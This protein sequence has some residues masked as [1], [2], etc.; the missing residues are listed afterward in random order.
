MLLGSSQGVSGELWA[1]RCL[2]ILLLEH[3]LLELR[4]ELWVEFECILTQLGLRAEA[5]GTVSESVLAEGYS[6][7]DLCGFSVELVRRLSRLNRVHDAIRGSRCEPA[8]WRYFLRTARD[9]SKLT[10]ARYAIPA[11][12]VL[13]EIESRLLITRGVEDPVERI[14]H[15]EGQGRAPK[16]LNAPA[17]ETSIL[18]GLSAGN[19]IYWLSER[20]SSELNALVEYPLTSAVLVIK[21]PGS[22]YE[23][24]IKRAG[25][26]GSRL[27]NVIT[28]KNGTEAP[29]SHRLFGGSL[30]WLAQRETAAAEIFSRIF[31]IVHGKDSPCSHGVLNSSVVTV[32]ADGGEAHILD[33]FTDEKQFGPGLSGVQHAMRIC[34]GGFPSDTGVAR[35]SYEGNEGAT[36]QF[37]GQARPQQA[38]IFGSSSFRLDRISAYLSDDGPDEYFDRGLGRG[39]TLSDVRWLADSVLEEI[40]G[41]VDVPPERYRTYP[42]DLSDVFR[43]PANRRRADENFLSVAAQIGECW[44]T[45]LGVR[46]FSDGE[47]FVLRNVGLKSLWTRG[48]WQVRIIFMDHDDLTVAG[49]RYQYLWPWREAGG[50]C[51]D[52]VHILGGPMGDETLPGEIGALQ[53]IYRVTGNIRDAGLRALKD[54]MIMAY[55][56]TQLHLAENPDLRS[57]FYPRFLEGRRDFDELVPELL[58]A[59]PQSDTWKPGAEERLRAKGYENE[60]VDEYT[61]TLASFRNYFEQMSFL[62]SR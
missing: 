17:Y 21:P 31:R 32:P 40:L 59:D 16:P 61:K 23:I 56:K 51:R 33:Y 12:E 30:G 26:R 35:A 5:T 3:K 7:T 11:R 18:D 50:M 27:L 36:L 46:G 45:L 1:E 34:V 22:D 48:K 58:A 14:R 29:T 20:S 38:I 41:E 10:L 47:S 19:R 25:V 42:Q 24:E 60:L 54:A 6:T 2:A 37:I 62:Y 9:V 8:D 28:E 13:T 52:K 39:Y 44:G 49:S 53:T 43:V 57:L 4:Q 15:P 55:D